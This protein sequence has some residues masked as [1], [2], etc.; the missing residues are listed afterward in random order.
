M[1][2]ETAAR[3]GSPDPRLESMQAVL[4]ER[5]CVRHR[6][7]G[8]DPAVLGLDSSYPPTHAWLEAPIAS[9]DRLFGW[10]GL[11]DKLGL[12]GFT[13][14][15]E[16]LAGVL[17]AQVGRIYQNGSLYADALNHATDLEREI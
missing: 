4:R 10:V 7:P 5:R 11:I 6:N 2:S 9:P 1:D 16:H 14:E 15:D 8:G 13:K 12:E 17:A 3:L